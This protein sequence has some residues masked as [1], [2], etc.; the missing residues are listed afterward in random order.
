MQGIRECNK[1]FLEERDN[2]VCKGISYHDFK[3]IDFS[4]LKQYEQ[5]FLTKYGDTDTTRR[6]LYSLYYGS[7]TNFRP[8]QAISMYTIANTKT[9]LDP[10]A[11][12]GGRCFG[13]MSYGANYIGFDTNIHLE[14]PYKKLIE[15]YNLHNKDISIYFE[16]SSTA[17]F[18]RFTYD[19]VLTSPPYYKRELYRHMPAYTSPSDF[20]C[21]FLKPMLSNAYL[22]LQ[23]GGHFFINLP[24]SFYSNIVD[25]L[26]RDCDA[27]YEYRKTKR[28]NTTYTEYIY[29]WIKPMDSD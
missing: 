1:Y 11:G 17:D 26:S 3:H 7:L 10:C 25:A 28:N 5:R 29:C 22:H 13:A 15:E 8:S 12:W 24:S 27:K 14:Q 2:T 4:Q 9:I 20:H 21:R 23:P 6:R 16:D 19:T 18:S